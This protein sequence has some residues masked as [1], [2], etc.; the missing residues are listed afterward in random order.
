MFTL[1]K[2]INLI[3]WKWLNSPDT[4]FAEKMN[5]RALESLSC[6]QLQICAS[7]TKLK[8]QRIIKSVAK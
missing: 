1:N 5:A 7:I 8:P 4:K 3:E 2:K 6:G